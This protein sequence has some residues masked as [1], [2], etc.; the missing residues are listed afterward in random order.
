MCSR[1]RVCVVI[2]QRLI[3]HVSHDGGGDGSTDEA[4]IYLSVSLCIFSA[5][6]SHCRLAFICVRR[7]IVLDLCVLYVRYVFERQASEENQ[8]LLL[9]NFVNA[10]FCVLKFT[11]CCNCSRLINMVWFLM[12]YCKYDRNVFLL[13]FNFVSKIRAHIE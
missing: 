6:C 13:G 7:T 4:L 9:L 10:R 11:I 5:Q 8:T 2:T 1:R 12:S 3:V